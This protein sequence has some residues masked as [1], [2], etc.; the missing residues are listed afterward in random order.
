[1]VAAFLSIKEEKIMYE[2]MIVVPDEVVEVNPHDAMLMYPEAEE[3][4]PW[5]AEPGVVYKI[6]SEDTD[7]AEEIM[8]EW[9]E[10]PQASQVQEVQPLFH[11]NPVYFM[12]ITVL[13]AVLIT[14]M[15]I[16]RKK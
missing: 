2:E 3:Y 12:S 16:R 11:A 6:T 9:A 5:L 4:N 8:L 10:E 14:G 7:I 13:L 1:M 15:R